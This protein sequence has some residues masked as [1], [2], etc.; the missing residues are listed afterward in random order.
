MSTHTGG[1]GI[2][3]IELLDDDRATDAGS[4]GG[5]S[6][7]PPAPPHRFRTWPWPPSPAAALTAVVAVVVAALCLALLP[8]SAGGRFDLAVVSASYTAAPNQTGISLQV[9]VQNLGS[10]M[11]ELTDLAVA[12][13]GLVPSGTDGGF[14]Q[15]G[16]PAALP[17]GQSVNIALVF[18]YDCRTS[19]EPPAATTMRA[20]GFDTRGLARTATLS[21]PAT[22]DPWSLGDRSDFCA[23]PAPQ[24]DLTVHY[25]GLGNTVTSVTPVRFNYTLVLTAPPSRSITVAGLTPD[26]SGEIMAVDPSLPLTVLDGQTVRLT[27]TWQVASCTLARSP[28]ATDGIQVMASNPREAEN[29]DVHLG[30]QYARDTVAE[31]ETVCP[32]I[33]SGG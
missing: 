20:A 14:T 23:L 27:V 18:T 21:L 10:S 33:G 12:Q 15:T 19:A 4:G 24:D 1:V 6:F 26:N 16:L 17:P 7:P 32:G 5:D 28:D 29:W 31:I 3:E 22:A 8:G 25:G 30:A 11:V 13:P 2:D 9:G